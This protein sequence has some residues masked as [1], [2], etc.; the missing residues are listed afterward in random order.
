[1]AQR[2]IEVRLEPESAPARFQVT[3]LERDTQTRHQVRLAPSFH[4]RIAGRMPPEAV[5]EAAFRFLLDRE[6]RESILPTFDISVISRY[7]PEFDRE[8]PRYLAAGGAGEG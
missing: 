8:L 5:I 6:P 3:V 1:M 2:T 4:Q 7:F